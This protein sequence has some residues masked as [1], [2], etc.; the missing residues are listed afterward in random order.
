MIYIIGA[1]SLHHSLQQNGDEELNQLADQL[2]PYVI[3]QPGVSL[4]PGAR[5][6]TKTVQHLLLDVGLEDSVIIWH[7][8]VNNTITKHPTDPRTPLNP[9]QLLAE[10][11]ALP[12]ITGIVYCER[13]GAAN[14]LADL[15]KLEVP[16][17]EIT[18][19]LIS[20][21]KQ[22][23]HELVNTYQRL[24]QPDFFE[25]H[26]LEIIVNNDCNLQALL[27]KKRKQKLSKKQREKNREAKKQRLEENQ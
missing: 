26:S 21:K 23:N 13:Q 18:T 11:R 27:S 10:I 8:V 2:R 1:S 7:D 16:V 4:H 14:V 25:L 6:Q 19:D 24:H 20:R 12:Q 3:S 5:N 22:Q 17:V 9:D 15:Q